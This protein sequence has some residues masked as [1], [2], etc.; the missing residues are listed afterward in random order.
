MVTRIMSKKRR[1]FFIHSRQYDN[2]IVQ[3]FLFSKGMNGYSYFVAS[4]KSRKKSFIIQIQ[5]NYKYRIITYKKS[6]M[7]FPRRLSGKRF[8][9]P[10]EALDFL[11][12][13][14]FE[15]GI[16]VYKSNA[17]NFIMGNHTEKGEPV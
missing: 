16:K 15:S 1:A 9:T 13:Y 14:L 17:V 6:E 3:Y 8:Y 7:S 5:K 10:E 2:L 4:D 12:D 11:A